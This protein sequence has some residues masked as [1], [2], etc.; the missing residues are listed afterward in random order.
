MGVNGIYGLSGS[1][2]DVESMVKVGMLSKQSELDK[3][4]QKY[5]K[6]E[7]KK[8]E[9]LSLY[10]ELQTFNNSTLSQYKMSSSMNARSASSANSAVVTATAN[11]TAATMTHYVEVN[12]L[13][14]AAYLIGTKMPD[15]VGTNT[16][17]DADGN[18]TTETKLTSTQLADYIFKSVEKGEGSN[19]VKVNGDDNQTFSLND[20][21]FEFSLNDGVNGMLKSS[22]DKAVTAYSTLGAA[23]TGSQTVVISA[24]ATGANSTGTLR[25]GITSNSKVLSLSYDNDLRTLLTSNATDTSTAL[26]YTFNDGTTTAD[27]SF[28]VADFNDTLDDFI[29]NLNEKFSEAGLT[30]EAMFTSKD[31]DGNGTYAGGISI[32]N[33]A[34]VG[35]DSKFSITNSTTSDNF[36]SALSAKNITARSGYFA[37]VLF[38]SGSS[39]TAV[40]NGDGIS[41]TVNGEN[42]KGTINGTA[43]SDLTL[44]NA[45]KISGN[46]VTFNGITYTAKNTTDINGVTITNGKPLTVAVTYGQ[47]LNG[48]TFNDL[49]SDIN[50]LGTNIRASYDTVQNNFY[51]YNKESGSE[52][53]MT[54]SI[55]TDRQ[56]TKDDGSTVDNNVGT[57]TEKFFDALG[58][59]QSAAGEIVGDALDFTAGKSSTLAGQ[60]AQVNIDGITYDLSSNKT[61]VNGVVY[62][63]KNV[64][65][66]GNKVAVSITQ[67]AD[68]IA[69][70]VKSFVD[71]YNAL[72]TKLY[73]WYDE[74][75]NEK[76]TPLTESQKS[77]L[78]DEQVEKWEEK[79]KAGLLYHDKTLGSIITELRSAVSEK[80]EGVN[81]KYNTI[82]S[83]GIST[84][85]LKGQLTFDED[86]LK[87]ALAEDP[88]AVYNVFAKLDSGEVYYYQTKD[89]KEFLSKEITG[90][91]VYDE[92]GKIKTKTVER[93]SYNGIAQRL[94]D[95]FMAGMKNVKNISGST[96]D[97][98]EDSELNNL[99][100]ELQTKMSNFKKMM[101]AF[102]TKLYKKYDAM[103]SSLALLG[104]QL[105][106]VTGAFQ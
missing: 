83:L 72:L 1:G 41:R 90:T 104:T 7:W 12:Q 32:Q 89:G 38:F 50:S 81:G 19:T 78:K 88:D 75:P 79:A 74:K 77:A 9:Y 13:A 29:K 99:M 33:T 3:M 67:D 97:V 60:D 51:F 10:G 102:E 80:V 11:A 6:N 8:T 18:D 54:F 14:S 76:Y 21:A 63:F 42:V 59:K 82:F 85:G 52:N 70:K 47:L 84:T 37:N 57:N 69:K 94:G 34:T 65:T 28:S 91:P 56:I 39:S 105:N 5:T 98:T 68:A 35:S 92:D 15:I 95:I 101:A 73:K 58:L 96:A 45:D 17:K 64:T 30:L 20:T 4:Q 100:R 61:T 31:T 22:N 48:Y 23:S 24:L 36:A 87:A 16:V 86:K 26:T 43:F 27:I 66:E 44:T 62:D 53:N 93:A 2:L 40:G 103:E 25:E 49:T 46:T 55:G 106:Y 71:D